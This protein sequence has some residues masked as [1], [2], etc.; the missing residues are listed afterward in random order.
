MAPMKPLKLVA[1]PF[2]TLIV[3]Y[4]ALLLTA[5]YLTA[6]SLGSVP[7]E[8]QWAAWMQRKLLTTP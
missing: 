8:G 1:L 5:G 7:G 6:I 3:L 2:A 4:A